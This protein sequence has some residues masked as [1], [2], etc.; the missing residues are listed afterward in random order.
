MS[1]SRRGFLVQAAA[2]QDALSAVIVAEL[3]DGVPCSV[4]YP[5]GGLQAEH[6]WISGEFDATL[7]RY[8]SGG[9]QRDETGEVEVRISVVWSAA[10][11]A[12]PR[13]RALELSQ[14]VEDAVSMDPTLGGV[15]EE[16]HVASARG[17]EAAPDEHSRQYGLSMRVAYQTTVVLS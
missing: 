13:D 15:V 6:I 11:M 4:G 16:A 7:P 5:A 17:N 2:V 1:N 8:V 9:F 14:I 12:G 3:P 10:D